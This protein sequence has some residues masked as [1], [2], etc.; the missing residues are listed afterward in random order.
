MS[1][2]YKITLLQQYVSVLILQYKCY[3]IRMRQLLQCHN[4]TMSLYYNVTVLQCHN[5]L[6][7][8]V[9][10]FGALY[11]F[12]PDLRNVTPTHMS[13]QKHSL[14]GKI[15]ARHFSLRV[16]KNFSNYEPYLIARIYV[17]TLG[18]NTSRYTRLYLVPNI[19]WA[20]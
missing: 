20:L 5:V 1:Q 7:N 15:I 19:L 14:H 9:A 6:F 12:L 10:Y 13:K 2:C 11:G 8:S 3:D 18:G 17:C 4:A 16:F